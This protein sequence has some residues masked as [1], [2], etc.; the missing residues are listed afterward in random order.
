MYKQVLLAT[1]LLFSVHAST[2]LSVTTSV[3][4]HSNCG[5]ANG[6][7]FAFATGGVMPY[8]YVWSGGVFD[9]NGVIGLAPGT[10]TVTVTDAAM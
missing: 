7:A 5:R 2:A 6:R 10:Y 1:L 8:T 3:Q 9:G 4:A